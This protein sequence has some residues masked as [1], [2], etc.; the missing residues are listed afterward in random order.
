MN[1]LSPLDFKIINVP[2]LRESY[3]TVLVCVDT[4][5]GLALDSVDCLHQWVRCCLRF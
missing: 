2:R 3:K 1:D 5:S 4:L